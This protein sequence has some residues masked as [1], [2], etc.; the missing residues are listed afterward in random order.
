MAALARIA[1][2]LV[3]VMLSGAPRIAAMHAP[4][5][6]HRCACR[7]HA[8][9]ER[10]CDCAICRKATLA[11]QASDERAPPCHRE[12]AKKAQAARE[13]SRPAD[14]PC[15]EGTCGTGSRP[16]VTVAGV[17]P[18]SPPAPQRFTVVPRCE[19]LSP[20]IAPGCTR[21]IEPETPPPR[22]A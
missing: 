9:G 3:A 19:A 18:F 11:A 8:S 16:A 14:G 22:V 15:I 5:E 2:P 21:S 7:A 10:E 13:A 12:A 17:E 20:A 4:A 6:R 1:A